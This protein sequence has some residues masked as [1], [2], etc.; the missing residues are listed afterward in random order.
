MRD[1][2]SVLN[3]SRSRSHSWQRC[4]IGLLKVDPYIEGQILGARQQRPWRGALGF[5]FS[6]LLF[7]WSNTHASTSPPTAI[8]TLTRHT[9]NT[10]LDLEPDNIRLR[11]IMLMIKMQNMTKVRQHRWKLE[12]GLV[13]YIPT[14]CFN[15]FSSTT[16]VA[17]SEK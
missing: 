16:K 14:I 10:F 4:R 17:T 9:K 8:S 13:R 5:H 7:Q 1:A 11:R 15:C 12:R 3:H 6:F 2:C